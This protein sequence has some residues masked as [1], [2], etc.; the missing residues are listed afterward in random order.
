MQA[1]TISP[2]HEQIEWTINRPIM[3]IRPEVCHIPEDDNLLVLMVLVP[4]DAEM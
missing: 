4:I 1:K 2:D 3:T